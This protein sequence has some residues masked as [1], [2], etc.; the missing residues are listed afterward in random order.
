M[1]L[2]SRIMLCLDNLSACPVTKGNKGYKNLCKINGIL[3]L[4][5]E[6]TTR[7]RRE[8]LDPTQEE[9]QEDGAAS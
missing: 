1:T 7:C 9:Q 3:T 4:N 8:Y 5:A 2:R 6:G